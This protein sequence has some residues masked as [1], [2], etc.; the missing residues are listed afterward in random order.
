M[1]IIYN[2]YFNRKKEFEAF[3]FGKTKLYQLLSVF[4]GLIIIKDKKEYEIIE[5]EESENAFICLQLYDANHIQLNREYYIQ[6][7]IFSSIKFNEAITPPNKVLPIKETKVFMNQYRDNINEMLKVYYS[8]DQ[9]QSASAEE[10]TPNK[11]EPSSIDIN[12]YKFEIANNQIIEVKNRKDNL[13]IKFIATELTK[14]VKSKQI[15]LYYSLNYKNINIVHIHYLDMS[16]LN[17]PIEG[18]VI[19]SK[20][21]IKAFK[22]QTNKN[23]NSNSNS[24]SSS[25]NRI[26]LL[27][28]SMKPFKIYHKGKKVHFTSQSFVHER[29]YQIRSISIDSSFNQYYVKIK[30]IPIGYLIK[31][32]PNDKIQGSQS[33]MNDYSPIE[34]CSKSNS[35]RGYI[36]ANLLFDE[37]KAILTDDLGFAFPPCTLI[38]LDPKDEIELDKQYIEH[39]KKNSSYEMKKYELIKKELKNYIKYNEKEVLLTELPKETI[40]KMLFTLKDYEN[41]AQMIA[42]YIEQKELW[43]KLDEIANMQIE[44]AEYIKLLSKY[45]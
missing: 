20:F 9:L 14:P 28:K 26:Y 19:D 23:T 7:E 25:S 15:E 22:Q 1:F 16:L 11:I 29:L 8:K 6:N 3:S 18:I 34:Q 43:E 45:Q 2:S 13:L 30:H 27:C 32:N 4:K 10:Y 5:I 31:T 35:Q 37:S 12:D 41:S 36:D 44:I 21:D 39:K 24:S 38:A 42:G 33:A 17:I 40:K